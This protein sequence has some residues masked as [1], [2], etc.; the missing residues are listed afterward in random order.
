M[1][2]GIGTAAAAMLGLFMFGE[3]RAQALV[4]DGEEIAAAKL[5]AAAKAEGKVSL[6]GARPSESIG[7]VFELFKKDT[8][9][10]IDYVRMPSNKMF[11]RVNAEF[12]AGKLDADYADLTDLA[13]VRDWVSR[14][15]LAKHKVPWHD[16]I[17]AEIKHPDGYWYYIARPIMV[18][19][20][21]TAEVAEKDVPTS[22]K[23]TLDPKWKGK[24][25]MQSIENGGS[26]F[27]AQA[28]LRITLGESAWPM[29]A[30][31]EPRLYSSVSTVLTDLV[32]GRI[33]VAYLDAS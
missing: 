28:F 20:V 23:D 19:G 17:A 2:R 14:G 29:L 7:P 26:A 6:F 13:M 1:L 12:A 22:W 33:G 15:I 3:A 25:G 31:N 18:I 10:A 9:L 5:F 16:R 21:N 4:I 32:R 8:G 11:E 24:L 30:K 27:G